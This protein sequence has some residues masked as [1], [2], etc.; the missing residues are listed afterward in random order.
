MQTA[1]LET[2][3]W[4]RAI[5]ANWLPRTILSFRCPFAMLSMLAG[6]AQMGREARQY[7]A[8]IKSDAR[9]TITVSL[10]WLSGRG[11]SGPVRMQNPGQ[12]RRAGD[13]PTRTKGG[14]WAYHE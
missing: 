6:K 14:C 7:L 10:L 5:S 1:S 11:G 4:D 12:S 13:L 3:A 9:N 2:A 8:Q